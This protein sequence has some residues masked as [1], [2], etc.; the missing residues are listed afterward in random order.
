MSR[1]S[2]WG[3]GVDY[4]ITCKR[5][6]K[7]SCMWNYQLEKGT[8]K[9]FERNGLDFDDAKIITCGDV[10]LWSGFIRFADKLQHACQVLHMLLIFGGNISI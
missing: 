3:R 1:T 9:V 7:P 5:F 2:I 10:T 4:I 6:W 8:I